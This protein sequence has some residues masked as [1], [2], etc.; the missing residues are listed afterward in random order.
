MR[1]LL[2]SLLC[3]A[4]AG[5]GL[6]AQD[7][8]PAGRAFTAQLRLEQAA[9]ESLFRAVGADRAEALLNVVMEKGQQPEATAE[10]WAQLH[11]ALGGLIELS[12]FQ[13]NP[14]RAAAYCGYQQMYYR[15]LEHDYAAALTSSE[16]GL[17]LQSRS[18][19]PQARYLHQKTIGENLLKLGRAEDAAGALEQAL[20]GNPDP[21]GATAAVTWR[22]IV[23][24]QLAAGKPARAKETLDRF[25]AEAQS[26]PALFR[27]H[28]LLAQA[29]WLIDREKY[30]DAVEALRQSAQAV[31]GDS[32][33]ISFQ[34]EIGTQAL[35]CLLAAMGGLPFEDAVALSERIG[36]DFQELPFPVASLANGVIRMRRRLAG[37]IERILREDLERLRQARAEASAP[38][39]ADALRS[40][41]ASYRALNAGREE[42][43][44]L[45]QARAL[46]MGMRDQAGPYGYY[47]VL[48]SLGEAHLRSGELAKARRA[49]EEVLKAI[50]G[51]VEMRTREQI[52]RLYGPALLGKARV[53]ELDEDVDEA[54]SLLEKAA[55]DPRCDR[56]G[57]LR[58]W[59]HLEAEARERPER[60]AELLRSAAAE[61]RARRDITGELYARLE[62]AQFLTV[63]GSSDAAKSE[64]AEVRRLAASSRVAD[65]SW[66]AEYVAGLV[67]ETERDAAA[68]IANYKSAVDRLDRLRAGL[69]QQEQ[70]QS[71]LDS[72]AVEELYRR[73]IALLMAT[74]KQ[75]EAWQ[76]LERGKARSFVEMLQGRRFAQVNAT[77]PE[78]RHLEE[79]LIALRVT[80]APEVQE[81]LRGAGKD[82]A[83]LHEELRSVQD[84]LTLVR[85]QAGLEQSRATEAL[86][87]RPVDLAA[88]RRALPRDTV[89]V[90]YGLLGDSI[91]AF[92][93]DRGGSRPIV[94][95][96]D[97]RQLRRNVLRLRGLLADPNSA[98]ELQELLG[99]VAEV[100]IA[101][102]LRQI[103]AGIKG[104]IVV[105][106]GA[107]C[108]LPF[109]ALP[110]GAKQLVLDR[111]AVS[112]LPSAS[113]LR[114]L[115][116]RFVASKDLFAG[117]LGNVAVEGW[118]PLPGTLREIGDIQKAAP[119][120]E[121]VSGPR[122]THD[123]VL[124][125]L[126]RHAEA[127]LATHGLVDEQSPLFSAL[128]TS[129]S[130]GEPARL[131]LYELTNAK[132]RA[133]LVVLSACETGLGKLLAGD[134]VAGLTRTLLQAGAETVVASLWKV[135]DESTALLMAGFHQR[136]RAGHGAAESMR[137]AALAVREKFAHPFY[138]APFVL[139][140]AR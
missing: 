110:V 75:D 85:Q 56:A 106:A 87:L 131:S 57:V 94:W 93:V 97:T 67:S 35:Y 133:R 48:V 127:H 3:L 119:E 129:P 100:V 13:G 138:W 96:A 98:A 72:G 50:D 34:F 108:Y 22:E 120:A 86:S 95:K 36:R 112:Y 10:D 64:V 121:V 113:A 38:R 2:Q 80:L 25:L 41:A 7:L 126:A 70:R 117:A 12:I 59:G 33:A 118:A 11:R 122:F 37:D 15:I 16:R 61:F 136:L 6:R 71:F 78:L 4:A 139:T 128:L 62:L 63:N 73:L 44:V 8:L 130:P 14:A 66:R 76:Y 79:R 134:E 19:Q 31:R 47:Q 9:D 52:V 18:E 32:K 137:E 30:T 135:S 20:E 114:Y 90:E 24:A 39:E 107:L 132:L 43:A 104:L 42:T 53:L 26:G 102:V 55:K 54:R 74:G 88:I 92:V 1:T 101:P 65:A 28:A 81:A 91:V 58:Q 49:F 140:G 60:A 69:T 68:A 17:E 124:R 46:E 125:G 21:F 116:R 83:L 109:Q 5:V 27:G 89:M 45:E 51:S 23:D 115:G 99:Q 84:R 82:A 103:P 111:F 29:V 105:P 77:S 123:S 40:L